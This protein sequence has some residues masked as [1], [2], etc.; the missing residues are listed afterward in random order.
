METGRGQLDAH[1]VI[2]DGTVTATKTECSVEQ[3][4]RKDKV[5]DGTTPPGV[6]GQEMEKL[7][8]EE[9]LGLHQAEERLK[10]DFIVRI[11]KTDAGSSQ[12][13]YLCRLCSQPLDGVS[14]A[15]RHIK[16]R[17]HRRAL[18]EKKEDECLRQ[19]PEPS[20]KHANAL[21]LCLLQL[22]SDVGLSERDSRQRVFIVTQM[23][24]VVQKTL[25]KVSLR[26]YGS[27]LTR[28]GF[29]TSDVNIDVCLPNDMT[30][31]AALISVSEILKSSDLYEEV[32]TDF[33]AKVPA[34]LCKHQKSGLLCKVGGGAETSFQNNQL[35]AHFG[36]L[37][38]HSLSLGLALRHWARLCDL[39]RPE[40]GG[41]PPYA[42]AL[43]TVFYLQQR[44][45]ALLPAPLSPRISGF[46][47]NHP[48]DFQLISVNNGSVT[49]ERRQGGNGGGQGSERTDEQP[50][51]TPGKTPLTRIADGPVPSL[52]VLWLGLLRFLC[53]EFAPS[54]WV[55]CLRTAEPVSR[56]AKA[57]PR[58]RLAIEDPFSPWRNVARCMSSQLVYDA[59]MEF[60]RNTYKYFATPCLG[61]QGVR[62]MEKLDSEV[63]GVTTSSR[64]QSN[65]KRFGE[66]L[67]R[68]KVGV[69][70]VV[71]NELKEEGQKKVGGKN[72]GKC[73]D[74]VEN[75][76]EEPNRD[77]N[78][79][80]GE[81]SN[82]ERP[83]D[84]NETEL[85]FVFDQKIFTKDKTTPVVCALC[86]KDGH[87]HSCC[88]DDASRLP[89]TALPSL[90][91]QHRNLLDIVCQQCFREF[92][93]TP[94]EESKRDQMLN[95]LERFIQREFDKCARLT[96]F[97]SSKNGFGFRH[98]DLDICL[99]FE[100][101][102]SAEELNC[103]QLIEDLAHALRKHTGLKNILPITTAKVPIVKFEYMC[104]LEAD[105]SLYNTLAQHNTRLLYMYSSIDSRV[106][107][108]GYTMKVFAKVC[109][110]GDASRGSLSSYAY[111]LMVL[112]F[113]QQRDPPVIPVLQELCNEGQNEP[114][115]MVDGWDVTFCSNLE[116]LDRLW[117]G[118]GKNRETVGELWLGLLRYYTECWQPSRKVVCVRRHAPLSTFEKEWT[119]S[120]MAIEDPFD[121]S[122]NLGAG[123]SRKMTNFIR[124]AFVNGRS[125][126]GS[127]MTGL[128]PHQTPFQYFFNP[129]T[130]TGGEGA[131]N[132]R[133]CR[134]CGKIGHFVKNCPRRRRP[135]RRE[136]RDGVGGEGQGGEIPGSGRE[137]RCYQC[138]ELG[139]VRRECTGTTRP[140]PAS[141]AHPASGHRPASRALVHE[142][143]RPSGYVKEAPAFLGLHPRL[144]VQ[145]SSQHHIQPLT[146]Q[147]NKIVNQP[148]AQRPAQPHGIL[149]HPHPHN[150]RQ[151]IPS[152]HNQPLASMYPPPPIAQLHTQHQTQPMSQMLLPSPAQ[153]NNQRHNQQ[154][155][156][157]NWMD[158][159]ALH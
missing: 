94:Q 50:V 79:Q 140:R 7:T 114:R 91:L 158:T 112:H 83:K 48:D 41:L 73:N 6:V 61:S 15:H 2:K 14:Q 150:H 22:Q 85:V 70:N 84:G 110:I 54:E 134:L 32:Q 76:E 106:R 26:L 46:D 74:G 86:K 109:D 156:P 77:V 35:L 65:A 81:Q 107:I 4:R 125:L 95:S 63:K 27:S 93:P 126:F 80:K 87:T 25:P 12:P 136:D 30:L 101:Y 16:E 97:G 153:P 42:F 130:L 47:P 56:Q 67:E 133:C 142:R 148:L 72:R 68:C 128:I 34:V 105:I 13:P 69:E 137:R 82:M 31:P 124:K 36:H 20:T 117:A 24:A 135:R 157:N 43:I 96:L 52:G 144:L 98:S 113:L 103:K 108:L 66:E 151:Q 58:R 129:E 8:A 155:K 141:G 18:Q 120:H 1:H 147:V 119:A 38:P 99:T 9:A 59:Y 131:P 111:T 152:A 132:D 29:K 149:A 19:L 37:E 90:S 143:G 62:P 49:W 5:R 10:R 55:V 159:F 71:E 145:P 146:Q 139:H 88:P 121:L 53:L 23:E 89:L 60:L 28:F 127:P 78:M 92:A 115:K 21:S 40:E 123:V 75:C 102:Q 44:H 11:R 64:E 17:R 33:H 154:H 45:P 118:R 116:M 39:D 104:G 138:G 3:S 57:W 122:H 51:V 100:G